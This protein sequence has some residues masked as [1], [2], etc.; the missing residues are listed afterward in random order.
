MSD[1]PEIHL[2]F[3]SQKNVFLYIW[4]VYG[5]W[6]KRSWWN[7]LLAHHLFGK[8]GSRSDLKYIFLTDHWCMRIILNSWIPGEQ[9]GLKMVCNRLLGNSD[10]FPLSGGKK[11]YIPILK[12]RSVKHT[13]LH[14]AIW[15]NIYCPY[16]KT[17]YWLYI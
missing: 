14:Y 15:Q 17:I 9:S 11:R 4:E 8:W 2:Y 1:A 7:F 6:K 5:G 13:F 12:Y 3:S 10:I 16:F